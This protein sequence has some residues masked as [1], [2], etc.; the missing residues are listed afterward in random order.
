MGLRIIQVDAFTNRPFS[1]N[2]AAVCVLEAPRPAVWMQAV[3]RE[4]NLSETAFLHRESSGYRLRWFTPE[5]EIALCGHATLAS[6]HVLWEEGHSRAPML[7]FHTLSGLLTATRAG[8]WIEM[9][10]PTEPVMP[11]ELPPTLLE[12]IGAKPVFTGKTPVRFFVELESAEVVRKLRPNL[13]L[14]AQV[15]PGRLIVTARSDDPRY[16][17]VS[18][19]FA[20][21]IGIPEDPVTGS[22][23]CA[24]PVYW[25]P[26]LGKKEFMAYQASARG[27]E[28]RVTLTSDRVFIQGQAVTVMRAELVDQVEGQWLMVD[29]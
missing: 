22:A 29:G 15:P 5:A 2:P 3:A 12:A 26:K 14:L 13:S 25:A 9:N 21:G 17:F 19:Y 18:R 7:E 4:M 16:D 10:F 20:P 1:G 28:L 27:G 6:A 23:H 8:N 24:L 11:A